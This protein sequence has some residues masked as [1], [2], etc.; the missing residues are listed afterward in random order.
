MT[1]LACAL[2]LTATFGCG[3]T[4]VRHVTPTRI[5][6]API[7]SSGAVIPPAQDPVAPKAD[8]VP[9]GTATPIVTPAAT[10]A[11]GKAVETVRMSWYVMGSRTA[12]G[13]PVQ[14][15]AHNCAGA[16]RWPLGH[17]LTLRNPD[18]AAT[19]RVRINDRGAFERLGRALDCMPAVWHALGIPL[20]RGVATVEVIG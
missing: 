6:D 17:H 2:A 4:P 11:V 1:K 3:P 9:S 12:S 16:R 15:H 8:R 14:P 5:Q 10:P 19:V 7:R 18:N 13:E 20:S